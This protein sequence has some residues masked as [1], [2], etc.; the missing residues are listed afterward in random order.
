MPTWVVIVS[1]HGDGAIESGREGNGQGGVPPEAAGA[2]QRLFAF[3]REVRHELFDEA[4]QAEL[5]TMY[6]GTG[7]G[8]VPVPP[9][10]MA[11]AVSP[12]LRG[13]VRCRGS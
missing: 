1:G 7:A 8:K 3:L 13:R 4:F 11:M 10:M 2:N 6:R 12:G 9:A 5:E